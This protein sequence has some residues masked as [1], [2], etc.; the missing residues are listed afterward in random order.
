MS[1][2]IT[3]RDELWI[4]FLQGEV[5]RSAFAD[6]PGFIGN[7]EEEGH[8]FL[9]FRRPSLTRVEALQKNVPGLRI[10]DHYRISYQDWLG[11]PVQGFEVGPLQIL[12]V[13]ETVSEHSGEQG[14]IH[15]D[16]GVVFGAG[17]HQTTRD[18][19]RALVRI[20]QDVGAENLTRVLDLGCGSGVLALGAARLGSKRVLALDTNPLAASTCRRNILGNQLEG[21]VLTIQGRAEEFVQVPADLVMANIHMEVLKTVIRDQGFGQKTWFILSGL[22]RS[23]TREVLSVLKTQGTD[24]I[25]VWDEDGTW[26]TVLGKN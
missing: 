25:Q 14:L 3:P 21:A 12:P 22:L 5:S 11:T 15:L 16:P 24:I 2:L 18:C 19:L 17:N 9:F 7:W 6:D 23:Q 10:K 4:Y 8:A 13:W 20:F 26:F 1:N